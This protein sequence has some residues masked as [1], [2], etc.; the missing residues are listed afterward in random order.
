MPIPS[1]HG[2]AVNGF[3]VVINGHL[4]ESLN[5]WFQDMDV[6]ALPDGNTLIVGKDL[7]QPAL[8][9]L[10]ISIRDFGIQ[11]VFVARKD[12]RGDQISK[13]LLKE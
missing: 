3:I 12:L 7:D 1:V 9:G 5:D 4:S 13:Y 10:L 6:I 2:G 11:L 8:F